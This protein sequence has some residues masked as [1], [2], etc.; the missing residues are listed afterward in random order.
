MTNSVRRFGVDGHRQRLVRFAVLGCSNAVI[1]YAIFALLVHSEQFPAQIR[2][3]LSQGCSYAVG[4]VWAFFWSRRWA[5]RGRGTG[6]LTVQ[7]TRFLL[8]QTLCLLLSILLV[9]FTIDG[10]GWGPLPGWLAAMSVVT[11]LNYLALTSWVFPVAR[12]SHRPRRGE[13]L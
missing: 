2:V 5:F 3:A 12:L 13:I 1:G 9:S 11:A 6:K 4:L 7:S 8:V 10:L